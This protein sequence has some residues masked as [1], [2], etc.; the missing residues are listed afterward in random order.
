MKFPSAYA[1]RSDLIF[2]SLFSLIFIV[3]G[4]GHFG[5]H[6]M[7][8][9]RLQDSPWLSLVNFIGSPSLLLYMS[10]FTLLFGGVA[11]LVGYRARSAAFVLLVTLLPITFVIHIAPGHVGPF[12]KNVAIMGGLIHFIVRGAGAYSIDENA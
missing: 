8:L 4:A 9:E 1:D 3:G 2:R 6:T 5:Q 7:M 10:G 12:L 11:L